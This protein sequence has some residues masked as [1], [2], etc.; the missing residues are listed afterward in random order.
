MNNIV[1][2]RILVEKQLKDYV[3]RRA[4]S[5]V[6]I[7]RIIWVLFKIY[8]YYLSTLFVACPHLNRASHY[9]YLSICSVFWSSSVHLQCLLKCSYTNK[10]SLCAP[11]TVVISH[12]CE[13]EV[14][15]LWE[16]SLWNLSN[17]IVL[18]KNNYILIGR[19]LRRS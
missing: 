6:I 2:S 18:M 13:F 12:F 7:L 10:L 9:Y 17:I 14:K 1:Q 19:H 15:C 11:C 8:S 16:S 3:T 4:N 5:S